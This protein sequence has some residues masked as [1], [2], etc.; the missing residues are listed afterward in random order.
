MYD[1]IIRTDLDLAA[2]IQ[3]EAGR[4][5]AKY[6]LAAKGWT[7]AW[8]KRKRALGL[9]NY[10]TKTIHLSRHYMSRWARSSDMWL[11]TLLHEVAHAL[12]PGT[13]HGA[14]WRDM[15]GTVAGLTP[16]EVTRCAVDV[17]EDDAPP[18]PWRVTCGACEG[19]V[20]TRH[21]LSTALSRYVSRCC[22]ARLVATAHATGNVIRL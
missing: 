13:H 15:F 7:F 17:R 18:A 3:W 5:L 12:T 8:N 19:L 6:G 10:T 11:R 22:K 1:A 21:K 20:V 2:R 14:A 16:A 4:A 9:C